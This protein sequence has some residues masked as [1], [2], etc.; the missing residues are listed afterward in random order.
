MDSPLG[1]GGPGGGNE[2]A[3]A[4]VA[5]EG[6]LRER[7]PD[8]PLERLGQLGHSLCQLWRLRVE[9]GVQHRDLGRTVEGRRSGEALV[10]DTRERVDVRAR[11]DG[12]ALDLLRRRVLER[13]DEGARAGC[14][15]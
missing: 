14:A 15:A 9:M 2:L 3:A 5:V 1:R 8:H 13:A 7:F 10:E 11:I 4:P 6:R 12:P